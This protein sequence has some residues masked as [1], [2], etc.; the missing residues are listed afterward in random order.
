M[1]S[2]TIVV[3]RPED[4]NCTLTRFLRDAGQKVLH[5][6]VT[7][8]APPENPAPLVNALKTIESYDWI[9]FSS[10]NAVDAVLDAHAMRPNT[11]KVAA[12]G[13]ATRKRLE[14]AGWSVDLTPDDAGAEHLAKAMLA[15]SPLPRRVLFPA[16]A[17]ALPTLA[18]RLR[19]GGIDVD[20]VVAYRTL[21]TLGAVEHWRE[22]LN[23]CTVDAVTFASPS[24]VF[25]LRAALT[26]S[27]FTKINDL[28][29]SAIGA[30][31]ADALRRN[32]LTVTTIAPRSTLED[33]AAA[34][35]A[36]L[37]ARPTAPK[38]LMQ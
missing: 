5:W 2:S 25:G 20:Q 29:V 18:Q 30:T 12:I 3:T 14:D 31:T 22:A 24:A 27:Y 38:G 32:G 21:H 16:S 36:A 19:D 7:S 34:T 37:A 26:E 8:I 4:E 23:T 35:L 9:V 33:L 11:I 28:I 6:Q 10:G 13:T 17:V 1:T 15:L